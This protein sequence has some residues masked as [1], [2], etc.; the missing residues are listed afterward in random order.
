[1]CKTSTEKVLNIYGKTQ[2]KAK[3]MQNLVREHAHWTQEAGYNVYMAVERASNS[4]TPRRGP[5]YKATGTE[6]GWTGQGQRD[7]AA[8]SPQP[9]AWPT[10]GFS[11]S[12]WAENGDLSLS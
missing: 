8:H 10:A 2:K 12:P 11:Y 9:A 3:W 7:S 5:Y 1:M 6:A 4:Q